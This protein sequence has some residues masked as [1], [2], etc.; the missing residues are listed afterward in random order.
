MKYIKRYEDEKF[1]YDV[2]DYVILANEN[3]WNI[4][5]CVKIIL[6]ELFSTTLDCDIY[7]PNNHVTS[8]KSDKRNY[9]PDNFDFWIDG[10]DISRVATA[11]EIETFEMKKNANKYN[12]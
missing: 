1:A 6:R 3:S 11:E 2:G 10:D 7:D 5:P 12:L 4:Y 8:I 9:Q